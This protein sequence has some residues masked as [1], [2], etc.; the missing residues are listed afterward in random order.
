M[1]KVYDRKGTVALIIHLHEYTRGIHL[2]EVVGGGEQETAL[3]RLYMFLPSATVI[4]SFSPSSSAGW[5]FR[6]AF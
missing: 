1:E 4:Q 5:Q 6:C 2:V 3:R